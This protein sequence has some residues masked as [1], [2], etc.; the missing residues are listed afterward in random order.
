MTYEELAL[1]QIIETNIV[2]NVTGE[3]V[4]GKIIFLNPEADLIYFLIRPIDGGWACKS[5][6]AMR[7]GRI[8]SAAKFQ[9]NIGN[10]L[11]VTQL[12]QYRLWKSGIYVVTKVLSDSEL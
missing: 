11:S 2:S 6:E 5:L 8:F 1:N 7:N 10:Y 12:L 4:K 3:K 9:E